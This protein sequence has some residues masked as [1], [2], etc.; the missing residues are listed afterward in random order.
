MRFLLK[1]NKNNKKTKNIGTIDPNKGFFDPDS[2][3]TQNNP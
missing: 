1:S 2:G 3:I